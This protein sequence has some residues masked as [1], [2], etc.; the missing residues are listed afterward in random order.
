MENTG[1]IT[2]YLVDVNIVDYKNKNDQDA[3]LHIAIVQVGLYEEN[4][5]IS[6][7]KYNAV[8]D[9][10]DERFELT[11]RKTVIK[12]TNRTAMSFGLGRKIAS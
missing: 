9:Q 12:D 7:A 11:I 1:A 10:L 8:K 5:I 4:V 6:E 2:G 3:K